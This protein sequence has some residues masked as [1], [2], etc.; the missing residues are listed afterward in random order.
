MRHVLVPV[1]SA[2]VGDVLEL[3]SLGGPDSFAVVTRVFADPEGDVHVCSVRA[4]GE[5]NDDICPSGTV[6]GMFDRVG[7]GCTLTPEGLRA[8][9]AEQ[10]KLPPAS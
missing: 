2:R 9:I 1:T 10:L 8:F 3:N 4:D 5:A 7:E 6:L